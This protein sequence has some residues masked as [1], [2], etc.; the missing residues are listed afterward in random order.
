MSYALLR[1][2]LFA[3]E[4][5]TA[6]HVTLASLK[7]LHRV[8]LSIARDAS[9]RR[10]VLTRFSQRYTDVRRYRDDAAQA[11]DGDIVMAEDLARVPFPDRV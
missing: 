7:A 8:G 4:A 5:E 3:L 10:L 2:V 9:V 1:P 6:H 11:F